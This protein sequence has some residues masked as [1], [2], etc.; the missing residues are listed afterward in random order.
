MRKN[1]S[2]GKVLKIDQPTLANMT[3]VLVGALK[4][5]GFDV[6]ASEN[7]STETVYVY[8]AEFEGDVELSLKK[9]AKYKIVPNMKEIDFD[10]EGRGMEAFKADAEDLAKELALKLDKD[11]E[12]S[13]LKEDFYE[14]A[15]VKL[16]SLE[17][18]RKCL[19]KGIE[20]FIDGIGPSGEGTAHVIDT[21][22]NA[23]TADFDQ[24]TLSDFGCSDEDEF[25]EKENGVDAIV[26][27]DSWGQSGC[28]FQE[29]D[30]YTVA[31]FDV[32]IWNED[33]LE[34][35]LSSSDSTKGFLVEIVMK[36]PTGKWGQVGYAGHIDD[37]DF[38]EGAIGWDAPE[39]TD[40]IATKEEA[41]K[42]TGLLVA[43]ARPVQDFTFRIVPVNA[44]G[45]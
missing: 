22:I 9:G 20:V 18:I 15:H 26:I 30:A 8:V 1:I 34:V 41:V 6:E 23:D 4:A 42:L 10:L 19:D 40:P 37:V 43:Q 39:D 21:T 24:D 2:E 31:D 17:Q 11:Y 28:N 29:L 12:R 27:D 45:L 13:N 25:W 5:E 38:E 3:D 16:T 14:D 32:Y 7:K 33:A 44:I 35:D 36:G